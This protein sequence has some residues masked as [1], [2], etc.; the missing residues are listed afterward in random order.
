MF[1]MLS[2]PEAGWN[3][4]DDDASAPKPIVTGGACPAVGPSR[5]NK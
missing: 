1:Y 4:P 3:L 5:G 2:D